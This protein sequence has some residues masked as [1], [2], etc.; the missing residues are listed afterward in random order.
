MP[1]VY[2]VMHWPHTNYSEDSWTTV[3][4]FSTLE[5]AIEAANRY[6]VDDEDDQAIIKVYDLDVERSLTEPH[7]AIW[8]DGEFTA[9]RLKKIADNERG[10]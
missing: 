2:V 9:D 1:Q 3:G 6:H 8:S 5:K 7:Y 4:V 10:G